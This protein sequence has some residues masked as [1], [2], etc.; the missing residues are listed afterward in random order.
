MQRA[1]A[2]CHRV[3]RR[4][5]RPLA[6]SRPAGETSSGAPR[7]TGRVRAPSHAPRRVEPSCR[8]SR[9]AAARR[10]T[11]PWGRASRRPH[12]RTRRILYLAET[13]QAERD[14]RET[15]QAA[16]RPGPR[17]RPPGSCA[18]SPRGRG[19]GSRPLLGNAL[20]DV[21]AILAAVNANRHHVDASKAEK[22]TCWRRCP[23]VLLDND[24]GRAATR[25]LLTRG[26]PGA[27]TA[28]AVM[29]AARTA[30]ATA[31]ATL[32]T[33]VTNREKTRNLVLPCRTNTLGRI[34]VMARTAPR[35]TH[36]SARAL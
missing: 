17:Q 4:G 21:I 14:G 7:S 26:T 33:A 1:G 32:T 25:A 5:G 23:I 15:R 35:R 19:P 6:A 22:P 9:G 8:R 34:V 10:R 36:F 13:R 11:R 28:T 3:R 18:G 30:V 29:A 27:G 2:A 31:A 16:A 24:A 12:T 20:P